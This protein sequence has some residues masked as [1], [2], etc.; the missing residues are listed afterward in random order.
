VL[1][2]NGAR[3]SPIASVPDLDIATFQS[4]INTNLCGAFYLAHAVIPQMRKQGS[5]VIINTSSI[6]GFGA[7]Y[8]LAAY[9]AAKG[10]LISLTKG[11]AIDHAREGIRAVTICPGYMNTRMTE[12]VRASGEDLK[13]DL[14]ESIPM[15]RAAELAEVAQALLFLA[16]DEASYITGHRELVVPVSDVN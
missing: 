15:G 1:F 7:D 5:G 13:A 4:L 12:G 8:G 9:N 10:G 3:L 14:F 11:I 2:H 16:S 6:S